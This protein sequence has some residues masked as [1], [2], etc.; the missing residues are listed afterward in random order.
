[1]HFEIHILFCSPISLHWVVTTTE[2][3]LPSIGVYQEMCKEWNKTKQWCFWNISYKP[4]LVA[5]KRPSSC[6]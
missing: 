5:K 2:G 6:L 3:H 4:H 1:M